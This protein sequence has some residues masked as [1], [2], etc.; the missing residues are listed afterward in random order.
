VDSP[1]PAPGWGFTLGLLEPIYRLKLFNLALCLA[2]FVVVFRL[3]HGRFSAVAGLAI[4]AVTGVYGCIALGF[5][6]PET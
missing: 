4:I 1:S 5:I 2:A 6:C 3:R